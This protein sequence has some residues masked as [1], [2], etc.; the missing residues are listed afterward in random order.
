M[1][2]A[3]S[4]DG[5]ELLEEIGPLVG[6]VAGCDQDDHGHGLFL[7]EPLLHRQVLRALLIEIKKNI[8]KRIN[9]LA[10]CQSAE[11]VVMRCGAIL[12]RGG[13]RKRTWAR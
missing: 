11:V 1:A 5:D 6:P 10:K 2:Y 8:N 3:L 4:G 13:W 7:D 9:K 12:R